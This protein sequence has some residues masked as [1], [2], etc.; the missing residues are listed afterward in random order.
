MINKVSQYNVASLGAHLLKHLP[1]LR[2]QLHPC[3]Q[4]QQLA[5]LDHCTIVL[6]HHTAKIGVRKEH[7]QPKTPFFG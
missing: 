4:V 5:L 7:K 1:G 2:F 6:N 3:Q